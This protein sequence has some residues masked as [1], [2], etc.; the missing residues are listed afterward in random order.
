MKSHNPILTKKQIGVILQL[1]GLAGVVLTWRYMT[2]HGGDQRVEYLFGA[3]FWTVRLWIVSFF[4]MIFYAGSYVW[5]TLLALVAMVFLCLLVAMGAFALSIFVD[6]PELRIVLGILV[7]LTIFL[8]L[9]DRSGKA[10]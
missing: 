1:I 4:F 5:P 7:V 8:F 10:R 9:R 6:T 2:P 3:E